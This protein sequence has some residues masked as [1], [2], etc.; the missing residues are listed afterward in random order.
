[1]EQ[2]LT[3]FCTLHCA[4]RKGN[5]AFNTIYL[6]FAVAWK[7]GSMLARHSKWRAATNWVKLGARH[8]APP[9]AELPPSG[10]SRSSAKATQRWQQS[11][12]TTMLTLRSNDEL[13]N[14]LGQVGAEGDTLVTPMSTPWAL[15][16]DVIRHRL[17]FSRPPNPLSSQTAAIG[18]E[19]WCL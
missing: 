13:N 2:G 15:T 12:R 18:L 9:A 7:L 4:A 19:L 10:R 5:G 17:C 16:R 14:G 3:G 6:S 1:M 8:H 11:K